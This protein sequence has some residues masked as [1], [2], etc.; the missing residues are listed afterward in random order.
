MP[1]TECKM[2]TSSIVVDT[3]QWKNQ[4]VNI[5]T[6]KSIYDV[7]TVTKKKPEC[8]KVPKYHCSSKWKITEKG[9]K[10]WKK[11]NYNLVPKVWSKELCI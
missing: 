6:C 7:I 3:T 11:V 10:V 2:E 5:Y 1:V 4:E 8:V 9:T